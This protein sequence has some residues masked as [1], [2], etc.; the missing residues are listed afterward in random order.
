M[1][2]IALT[3]MGLMAGLGLAAVIV[4]IPRWL[5]RVPYAPL[6]WLILGVGKMR[7]REGATPTAEVAPWSRCLQRS[8]VSRSKLRV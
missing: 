1:R 6:S 2:L 5:R 8:C 4:D 7:C 3:V